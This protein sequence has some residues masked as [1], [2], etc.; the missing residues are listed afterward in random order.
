MFIVQ[1]QFPVLPPPL[2][3][4][5][6]AASVRLRLTSCS[7]LFSCL[8]SCLVS[9]S[10]PSCCKEDPNHHDPLLPVAFRPAFL[11]PQSAKPRPKQAKGQ[12]TWNASSMVKQDHGKADVLQHCPT[13]HRGEQSLDLSLFRFAEAR[14]FGIRGHTRPGSRH[15]RCHD[16][17]PKRGPRLVHA[18]S[19]PWPWLGE[20]G[21]LEACLE[22][23]LFEI[24][25]QKPITAVMWALEP[26][27]NW[28]IVEGYRGWLL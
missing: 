8:L 25:F 5:L 21:G 2:L 16:W 26:E 24:F 18:P 6:D 13:R 10:F 27:S 14:R 11:R 20:R 3:P 9:C 22:E 15:P 1:V 12:R 19:P 4:P 7:C 23:S 28:H 17:L